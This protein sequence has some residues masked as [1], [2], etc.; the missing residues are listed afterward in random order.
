MTT[1]T[2]DKVDSNITGLA[3]AE[4]ICLKE[5][6]TVA[7]DGFAPEWQVMEPNSYADFGGEISTVARQPLSAGRQRKK[8]TVTD[9]N[10]GGGFNTDVTRTNMPKWMQGFFFANARQKGSTKPLNGAKIALTSVATADDSFNAAAGLTRFVA[11]HIVKAVGFLATNN[12]RH[13]VSTVATGKVTVAENLTNEAAPSA[14]AYL[15]AVG[16]RFGAGVASLTASATAAVLAITGTAFASGTYTLADAPTAADT[17][18]IG[19]TVYTYSAT[20]PLAAYEVLIGADEDATAAN[21]VAAINAGTGAGT[22]YGIGTLVHPT[23][24]ASA[25]AGVVTVTAKVSGTPS[26]A[27]ATTEAGTNSSW[28]AATLAGGTGV[29]FDTLGLVPGEWVFVGGD[30]TDSKFTT[31]ASTNRPG[32]ARIA[33]MTNA[34]LTFDDTTWT[35]QTDAGTGKTIE[36]FFGTVA[37]NEPEPVDIITRSY[38]MERTL[39]VD[40]SGLPQSQYIKGCIA[41]ELTMNIPTADKIT[42]DLKYIGLDDEA[43]TGAEGLK[44]GTR[45]VAQG[46]DAYN[47]SLDIYRVRMAIVDPTE[48]NNDALFGYVEQA[49]ITINNNATPNKALGYLGGFSVSVGNFDV[50]GS[51]TAYFTTVEALQAI[52]AN[53]DLTYNVI[54]AADNGGFIFDTPLLGVSGGRLDVALNAAVKIPLESSGAQN[55]NG[56]TLLST[57]FEY[58]PDAAM[59]A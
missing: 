43:R 45:L 9:L 55:A 59:P 20:L 21:L 47:T 37:R 58:L 53:A 40:D 56:Y 31:T 48:I 36:L 25:V 29:G 5:L 8:G 46:E 6:P 12:G 10:S 4:E 2:V 51:I 11:G 27:I 35:P 32:Y 39:G 44:E 38:Q 14:L 57:W 33:S 7:S 54:V 24:A 1:C 26:N 28:G 42:I 18:T 41:N 17:V 49:T 19:T 52:R 34:A 22:L 16:F 23:V 30:V 13:L 50:G 3:L 15:Q